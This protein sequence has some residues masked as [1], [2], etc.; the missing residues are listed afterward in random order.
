[1][2]AR[3]KDASDFTLGQEVAVLMYAPHFME[4][5][6]D[7]ARRFMVAYLQGLREYYEAFF[8]GKQHQDEVIAVLTRYTSI[9]DPSVFAQMVA[10]GVDPKGRVNVESLRADQDWFVGRGKQQAPVPMDQV[11]DHQYVNAAL[12]TLGILD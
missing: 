9:K 8:R 5:R 3:W 2:L 6:P 11:V 4:T 7:T 10:H 1:M 12:A